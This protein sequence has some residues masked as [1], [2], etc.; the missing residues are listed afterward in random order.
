MLLRSSMMSNCGQ[1]TDPLPPHERQQA[2]LD[3]VGLLILQHNR[4]TLLYQVADVMEILAAQ[5]HDSP[6]LLETRADDTLRNAVRGRA[7]ATG[8]AAR[9]GRS[10][11]QAG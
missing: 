10:P 5:R 4:G 9:A 8:R 3:Q 11:P 1:R 7:P 6:F 2:C